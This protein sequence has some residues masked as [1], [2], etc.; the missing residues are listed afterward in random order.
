MWDP[1]GTQSKHWR[2]LQ[3]RHI[4]KSAASRR[5]ASS[6]VVFFFFKAE[7]LHLCETLMFDLEEKIHQLQT[8]MS[9]CVKSSFER[10]PYNEKLQANR[11]IS[12]VFKV[13]AAGDTNRSV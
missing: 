13:Q 9:K 5:L 7:F 11:T 12:S 4:I 10:P 3:R 6:F 1:D 8:L 2:P